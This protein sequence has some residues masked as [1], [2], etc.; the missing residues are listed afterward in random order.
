MWKPPTRYEKVDWVIAALDDRRHKFEE[1]R[2]AHESL[3]RDEKKAREKIEEAAKPVEAIKESGAYKEAAKFA[4]AYPSTKILESLTA[5]PTTTLGQITKIFKSLTATPTT[6]A[7]ARET[8]KKLKECEKVFAKLEEAEAARASAIEAHKKICKKICNTD[9]GSG[10]GDDPYLYKLLKDLP[11]EAKEPAPLDGQAERLKAARAA[12]RKERTALLVQQEKTEKLFKYA[13]SVCHDPDSRS[14]TY[15]VLPLPVVH[16]RLSDT[17][18]GSPPARNRVIISTDEPLTTNPS[19]KN[20]SK[21]RH[22]TA[23]TEHAVRRTSPIELDDWPIA[24]S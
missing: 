4:L 13:Q 2:E 19:K 18:T 22:S 12:F 14:H 1:L 11:K 17:P 7:K 21:V 6:S 3:A 8:E 9:R 16:R 23:N 10:Y 24:R 5:G 20:Q 15:T